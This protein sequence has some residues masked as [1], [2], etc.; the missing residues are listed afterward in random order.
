MRILL[1]EDNEQLTRHMRDRFAAERIS[2]DAVT[3]V[4]DALRVATSAAY[5]GCIVDRALSDRV[6][7]LHFVAQLRALGSSM[8]ILVLSALADVTERIKGLRAGADDYLAKPFDFGELHARMVALGR[9]QSG[10][11]AGEVELHVQDLRMDLCTRTVKRGDRVI[12]LQPMEFRV[13]EFLL[14]HSGQVVT[15]RMLLERVWEQGFDPG[16]NI[17]DV[18]ISKLRAKIDA[19][20]DQPLL[21]TIRSIGYMLKK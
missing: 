2:L 9:R 14:R 6:D 7:G 19:G 4:A 3:T 15:R 1:V 16:T 13:L 21:H 12:A 8:P 5:D 10:S 18:Q 11:R 17:I 20:F